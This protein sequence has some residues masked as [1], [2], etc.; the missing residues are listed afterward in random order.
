MRENMPRMQQETRWQREPRWQRELE[1]FCRIK[2]L[3]VLENNV[4]D[5]FQYPHDGAVARGSILPLTA[6]LHYLFRDMGYQQIVCYDHLRGFHNDCES[7][8]TQ[9]F[10]QMLG[11][12]VVDGTIPAPFKQGRTVSAPFIVRQAL[13]QREQSTAI[14]MNF[15]SRCIAASDRM[16]QSEIDSFMLLEQA[17]LEAQD[18]RVPAGTVKNLCILIV[19]KLND[20]PSWF[21]LQDPNL[22]AI[23]IPTPSREEREQFVKGASFPTFF[24]KAVREE[25]MPYYD[26]HPAE[27]TQLQDRFI[28]LTEGMSFIELNGLRRLCKNEGYRVSDF[29]DV[30][31]LFK[32]GIRENPWKNLDWNAFQQSRQALEKRVKGQHTA[33][34]KTL[35]ILKRA[36]TGLGGLQHSSHMKPKGVMFFA[37]PTG[38]GKTETAKALAELVFGDERA[39]IRF[40]MSEYSQAHSD[41]RLLGAP[42]GYVGYEAGGQLTNAV[43]EHPFSILLFDEIE[44]AH[45]SILDKFLQILEDGRM[46]DGQGN[47][48]YFSEC[49]I[50]FTSNLGVYTL[51]EEGRRRPNATADMPYPQV[52]QR[53]RQAIDAYFKLQ[54]GRPEILNRIGENIVVFD[55][56]R[57][58]VAASILD[59][60]LARIAARLQEDNRVTLTLQPE[61]RQALLDRVLTNLD[62]GGR[63]VGN[64]VESMLI[65][66]LARYLF[67]HPGVTEVTILDVSQENELFS[68]TVG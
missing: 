4:L 51:D 42:P 61:A 21:Y 32:Y 43:R 58:E 2:P 37:G 1:I 31:D 63:G 57:P 59:A 15:A 29:C 23:A 24:T 44:K 13:S 27:L 8:C 20:L 53:I 60:Q 17:A 9:R 68:L 50:I 64:I 67:D 33:I 38:T 18:V 35:D 5:M 34:E 48:V 46:T 36:M 55:F 30:I 40:D 45:P 6:Y 54:L 14:I 10:A 39:C 28:A 3:I 16:E 65:N 7:A 49:I 62:N 19:S 12:N 25:D 41:Q 66:P 52:Q 47:T 56:I 26:Q 22:K 11:L